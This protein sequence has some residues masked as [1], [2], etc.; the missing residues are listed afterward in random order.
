MVDRAEARAQPNDIELGMTTQENSMS[1][2]PAAGPAK[3]MTPFEV[4]DSFIV[5][6]QDR[7]GQV[8]NVEFIQGLKSNWQ[9]A[10]KFGL[11]RNIVLDDVPQEKYD[12]VFGQIDND[13]SKSI[14]VR[15]DLYRQ[16]SEVLISLSTCIADL[17]ASQ[18]LRAWGYKAG[19][20]G[21]PPLREWLQGQIPQGNC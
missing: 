3:S 18:V 13:G 20:V 2:T 6:D 16:A 12:L 19:G 4:I 9:I 14:N 10:Q 8:S 21:G 17:G 5:L 1:T 11:E 7:D 15:F